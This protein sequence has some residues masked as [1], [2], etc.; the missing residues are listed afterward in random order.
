METL[1][2]VQCYGFRVQ[3]FSRIRVWSLDIWGAWDLG[4][5]ALGCWG[6]CRRLWQSK[7]L[8]RVRVGS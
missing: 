2:R 5:W 6:H 1:G 3:D 4:G 7:C 8:F